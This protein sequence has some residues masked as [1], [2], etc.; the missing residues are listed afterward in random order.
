MAGTYEPVAVLGIGAM[1]HG[2][3][4]GAPRFAALG[5]LAGEWQQAVGQGLGGQDLTVVTRI[6]EQQGRT[7]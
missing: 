5:C 7:P 3:A 6:I 2:K 4:A 1:G